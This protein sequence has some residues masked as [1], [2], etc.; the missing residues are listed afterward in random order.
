MNIIT[1]TM[2]MTVNATSI[3]TMTTAGNATSTT[4]MT[5]AGN[6]MIIITTITIIMQTRCL[7]AGELKPLFR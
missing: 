1:T 6:A 7:P 2:A 4:T 5:T 3:T